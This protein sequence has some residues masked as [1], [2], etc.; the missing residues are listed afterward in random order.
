MTKFVTCPLLHFLH[1][2]AY[3]NIY[4]AGRLRNH[5][6]DG[7]GNENDKKAMVYISKKKQLCTCITLFCTFLSRRC[8]TTT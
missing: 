8:T 4:I 5:D 3:Q 6:D 1:L 2:K 7:D